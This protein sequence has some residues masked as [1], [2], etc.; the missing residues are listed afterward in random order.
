MEWSGGMGEWAGAW[1]GGIRWVGHGE[2]WGY[3]AEQGG[4][5]GEWAGPGVGGGMEFGWD[6][7][8]SGGIVCGGMERGRDMMWSGA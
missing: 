3:D 8:W 7:E 4:G 2:G 6:M 1:S 5:M